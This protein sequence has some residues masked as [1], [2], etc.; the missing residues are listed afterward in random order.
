LQTA[1]YLKLKSI[2][3]KCDFAWI[4]KK[5]SHHSFSF[6]LFQAYHIFPK[7][8]NGQSKLDPYVEQAPHPPDEAAIT[9]THIPL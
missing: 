5:V 7:V 9:V 8:E 1:L 2:P 4:S 3:G 6:P